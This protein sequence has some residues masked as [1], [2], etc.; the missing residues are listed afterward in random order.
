[1]R[2]HGAAGLTGVEYFTVEAGGALEP[3]RNLVAEVIVAE[4]VATDTAAANTT[5]GVKNLYLGLLCFE[6]I[7]LCVSLH[8]IGQFGITYTL[9]L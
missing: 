4:G 3:R 9:Y 6:F 7:V 5:S 1:M 8:Y 2:A